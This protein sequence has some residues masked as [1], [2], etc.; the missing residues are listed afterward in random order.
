MSLTPRRLRASLYSFATLALVAGA[1]TLPQTLET[2]AHGATRPEV[3]ASKAATGSRPFKASGYWNTR[4]GNAP[5]SPHSAA[6]I[7]DAEAHSG[8]H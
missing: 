5:A 3:T 4:L 6:W 1:A 2:A 8:S 7:H